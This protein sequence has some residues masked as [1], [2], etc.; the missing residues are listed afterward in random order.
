MANRRKAGGTQNFF[1]RPSRI[2]NNPWEIDRPQTAIARLVAQR[3]FQ[4][5]VLDIGCGIGDNATYIASQSRNARVTAVDLVNFDNFFWSF[6][7]NELFSGS[8][9]S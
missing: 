7:L 6:E 4:G 1:L 8:I 5:N 9:I 3:I 2:G